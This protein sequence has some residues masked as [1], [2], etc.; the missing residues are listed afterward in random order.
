MSPRNKK[1]NLEI[2][3]ERREQILFAAL[4]LFARRG[5]VATKVGDIAKEANISHGLLYH[6]FKSKDTIFLELVEMAIKGS[7][8]VKYFQDLDIEPIDKIKLIAK[9]VLDEIEK[10]IET[11]YFFMMMV[12][13]TVLDTVPENIKNKISN[14]KIP[15][16]TIVNIIKEG[17]EKNQIIDDD[18]LSL[19]N[20]F[21]AMIQ[22]IATNKVC[23]GKEFIL[24]KP[25]LLVKILKK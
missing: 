19:A 21:W 8:S 2:K 12:H 5:I 20:T 4:K 17:Q 24:P 11:A 18:P 16:I 22:G 14:Y 25:E 23:K 7:S 10:N 15:A 3:D 13:A 9:M 1:Q 6:Y